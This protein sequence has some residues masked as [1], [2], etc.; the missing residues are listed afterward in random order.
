[1]ARQSPLSGETAGSDTGGALKTSA[2]RL[3]CGSAAAHMGE[4]VSICMHVV[5]ECAQNQRHP[6]SSLSLAG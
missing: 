1:M 2:E 3:C 4:I 6:S 5:L